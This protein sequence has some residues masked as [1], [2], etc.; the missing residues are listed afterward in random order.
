MKLW[1]RLPNHNHLTGGEKNYF[2][3]QNVTF[4]LRHGVNGK[5]AVSSSEMRVCISDDDLNEVNMIGAR[6]VVLKYLHGLGHNLI[7]PSNV[8]GEQDVR[9]NITPEDSIQ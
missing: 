8:L 1:S 7:K 4:Y 6:E 2:F 5:L 3:L 9:T